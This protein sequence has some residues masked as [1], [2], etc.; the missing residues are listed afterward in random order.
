[1][2]PLLNI[3]AVLLSMTTMLGI[4]FHDMSIDKAASVALKLPSAAATNT[5]GTPAEGA[6]KKG[7]AHTHV[8]TIEAPQRTAAN[9]KTPDRKVSIKKTRH[10]NGSGK[11]IVWPS[12]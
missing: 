10:Q 4:L 8:H 3:S 2:T 5:N 12:T 6:L 1:M 11:G 7:H 9:I